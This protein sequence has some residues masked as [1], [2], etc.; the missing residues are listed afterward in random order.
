MGCGGGFEF[1]GDEVATELDVLVG[2]IGVLVDGI[3]EAGIVKATSI[4][5]HCDSINSTPLMFTQPM[6]SPTSI[7]NHVLLPFFPK[8]VPVSPSK[9]TGICVG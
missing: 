5:S 1:P 6:R 7:L 2:G 4:G 8:I 9:S 3:G